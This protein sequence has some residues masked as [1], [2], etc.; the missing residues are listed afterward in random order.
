MLPFGVGICCTEYMQHMQSQA[1]VEKSVPRMYI[2]M[3]RIS[4]VHLEFYVC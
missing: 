3:L 2:R 1:K 4:I